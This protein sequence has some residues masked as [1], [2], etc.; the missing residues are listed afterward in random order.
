MGGALL[1]ALGRRCKHFK[2][3]FAAHFANH[4]SF[5]PVPPFLRVDICLV[6]IQ[7]MIA[8][9]PGMGVVPAALYFPCLLGG[10]G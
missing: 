3:C 9:S 2:P 1:V 6:Q 8:L 5:Q 10:G 7:I 4:L